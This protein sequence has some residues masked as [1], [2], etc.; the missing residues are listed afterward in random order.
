VASAK[1]PLFVGNVAIAPEQIASSGTTLLVRDV[2]GR[3]LGQPTGAFWFLAPRAVVDADGVVHLVWA[4]PDRTTAPERT[5]WGA[6]QPASLWAASYHAS[7]GWSAAVQ[8][9]AGRFS[10]RKGLLDGIARDGDR[11]GF[12][13][14]GPRRTGEGLLF[15][16][17][18]SGQWQVYVVD[19]GAGG[20]YLSAV[21]RGRT[22]IL[23]SIEADRS[24][25][26]DQNSVFVRTSGDGGAT[27]S[28]AHLVSRS[29]ATPADNVR[30]R[31]TR[32]GTL[33]LLWSQTRQDGS[34]V[35]RLVWSN[36]QAR[37]WSAPQD[38]P[39]PG[40]ISTPQIVLDGCDRLYAAFEHPTSPGSHVDMATWRG[41]WQSPKHLPQAD[42]GADLSLALGIDGR[43]V[44]YFSTQHG[45]TP[46]GHVIVSQ[47]RRKLGR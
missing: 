13:I 23:A 41:Q 7:R 33:L 28:P 16:T 5:P 14:R 37:S 11:L 22:V 46:Q 12:A 1:G 32:D 18:H 27:W 29:G 31:V 38:L 43:P 6:L 4:E 26:A 19:P 47:P 44:L 39:L 17:R 2:M 20:A 36:D 42:G 40:P 34:Q 9:Y 45:S 35:L 10:W 8:L 21:L 3:S 24:V 30:L 25:G 15:V